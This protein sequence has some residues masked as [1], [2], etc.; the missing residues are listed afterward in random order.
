LNHHDGALC[1]AIRLRFIDV[2][3]VII[4]TR[5]NNNITHSAQTPYGFNRFSCGGFSPQ[6]TGAV[7]VVDSNTKMGGLQLKLFGR[8]RSA[9]K[10]GSFRDLFESKAFNSKPLI[11]SLQPKAFNL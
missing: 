11:Q 10:R 7:L 9:I 6:K 1:P 5:Q 8:Q 3:L 4:R 2:K